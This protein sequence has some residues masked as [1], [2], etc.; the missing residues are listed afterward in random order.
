[1]LVEG[2]T[3]TRETTSQGSGGSPVNFL[4][5]ATCDAILE[6]LRDADGMMPDLASPDSPA[7][8]LEMDMT[9]HDRYT[10]TKVKRT[11]EKGINTF[12]D[13]THTAT[14][15]VSRPHRWTSSTQTDPSVV[16]SQDQSTQDHLLPRRSHAFN[17]TA[18][19]A[20]Y[21]AIT[22]TARPGS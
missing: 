5:T 17:Q 15:V 22:Q 12:T 2:P 11:A 18:R 4:D 6:G 7:P 13:V 1:M 9:P 3:D 14:Q 16:P 21:H 19:P 20:R 8:E 10:Q